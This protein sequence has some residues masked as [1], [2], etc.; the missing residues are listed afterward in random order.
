MNRPLSSAWNAPQVVIRAGNLGLATVLA[1]RRASVPRLLALTGRIT[2]PAR[3]RRHHNVM[4]PQHSCPCLAHQQSPD[5][6]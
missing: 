3:P 2:D 1:R 5:V 4:M 6:G